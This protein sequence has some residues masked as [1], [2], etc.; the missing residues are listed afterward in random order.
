[1]ADLIRQFRRRY[2]FHR[3]SSQTVFELLHYPNQTISSITSLPPPRTSQAQ[4][5]TRRNY[6][7][8]T[9]RSAFDANLLRLLRNEILYERDRSPL[10]QP[11]MEINGFAVDRRPGEQWI[12]MGKMSGENEEIKIEVT[13]FDGSAPVAQSHD[14][15]GGKVVE[16]VKLHITLI[17]SIFKAGYDDVVEFICSAWPDAL[18]ID[19]VYLRARSVIPYQPYLGPLFKE[20]DEKLQASLFEFLEV[21]G[22]DDDLCAFLHK[23]VKDKDRTE[24]IRWLETVKSFVEKKVA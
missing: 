5:Q 17:V 14:G 24:Y 1:M 9:R 10:E 13:M 12:R 22:I 15:R 16:E 18:D 20:L 2:A 21:R 19:R 11:V 8:E 23:S 7:S 4:T 3:Q 6:I